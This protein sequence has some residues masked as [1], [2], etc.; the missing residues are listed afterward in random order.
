[1]TQQRCSCSEFL[2][3]HRAPIGKCPVTAGLNAC[4]VLAAKCAPVPER[5]DLGTRGLRCF[6][7]LSLV[8]RK[9]KQRRFNSCL[10]LS[11]SR[12]VF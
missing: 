10:A 3:V 2:P 11:V 1:M 9:R 8:T 5:F 7:E 4:A 12:R 6:F